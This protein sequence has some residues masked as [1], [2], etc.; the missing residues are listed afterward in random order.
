VSRP[1]RG[2]RFRGW[3]GLT[4]IAL[5]LGGLGRPGAGH[6]HAI[7]MESTPRHR[8]AVAAPRRLV[9]RF[10]SRIEKRLSSTALV[11][12]DSRSILLVRQESDTPPDTLGYALPDLAPGAYRV[13]WRVLAVDGHLTEGVLLFTVVGP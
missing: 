1:R 8:E 13:K 10:N 3:L 11:G 7:V 9:L 12:P 5:V 4:L 2:T 6:A